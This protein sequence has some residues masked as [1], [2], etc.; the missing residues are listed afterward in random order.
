MTQATVKATQEVVLQ[1]VPAE[2]AFREA[3]D[4]VNAQLAKDTKNK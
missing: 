4:T 3:Q 1:H 2:K